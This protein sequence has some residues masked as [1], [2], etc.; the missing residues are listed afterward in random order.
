M[1]KRTAALIGALALS[2]AGLSAHGAGTDLEFYTG[3]DL[4]AQCTAKPADADYQPRYA[5]CLGYVIGVSDA[6]QAEQG[7]GH[8]ATVC[9]QA[10][11]QAPQLV[12]AVQQYLE[13]HPDKRR[14]AAP[15]LVVGALSAAFPCR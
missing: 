1:V 8:L 13:T 14:V 12:A 11:N 10:S 9:I 7:G 6:L 3:D 4:F 15:D 2:L 5:R